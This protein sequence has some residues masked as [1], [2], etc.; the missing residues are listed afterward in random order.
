MSVSACQAVPSWAQQLTLLFL[1]NR[2]TLRGLLC[3]FVLQLMKA[4]YNETYYDR[5]AYYLSDFSLTLL[6]SLS[7]SMFPF[8]GLVGSLMV[9]F[10]VNKLGR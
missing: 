4:F 8:G 9:G 1:Q 5:T 3:C 10:L 6:W 2:V 7:V